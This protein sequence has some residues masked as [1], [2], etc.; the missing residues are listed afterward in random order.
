ME[1][2]D[3]LAGFPFVISLMAGAAAYAGGL[4]LRRGL[5][6]A[7]DG[8][9]PGW[10]SAIMRGLGLVCMA[11]SFA[12]AWSLQPRVGQVGLIT[13]LGTYSPS[14]LAREALTP[15]LLARLVVSCLFVLG[16]LALVGWALNARIR[17]LIVGHTPDRLAARAPYSRIRRPVTLGL[18]MGLL[19]GTLLAGTL[20][21][22]ACLILAV[23]LGWILQE[24]DDLD[25][26]SRV[27]WVAEQQ[28]RIPRFIPRLGL[29]RGRRD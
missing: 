26:R 15:G 1:T 14:A 6:L 8:R 18:G 20:G 4:L 12:W 2:P 28:R 3:W 9:A 17:N 11:A 10:P 16:G 29:R 24:F 27:A 25:L 13:T 23:A 7:T 22:W 5:A 19:G 21:S